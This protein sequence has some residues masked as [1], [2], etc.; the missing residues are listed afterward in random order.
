MEFKTLK[1]AVNWA[2]DMAYGPK[3]K[4]KTGT[5]DMMSFYMKYCDVYNDYEI[6]NLL[7]SKNDHYLDELNT[8]VH[9]CIEQAN[10]GLRRDVRLSNAR[11]LKMLIDDIRYD[12]F[13]HITN[14]TLEGW[15]DDTLQTAV[16]IL[17]YCKSIASNPLYKELLKLHSSFYTMILELQSAVRID[18]HI[19][20][21][22]KVKLK[23]KKVLKHNMAILSTVNLDSLIKNLSN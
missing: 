18:D 5:G 6:F 23:P 3:P 11:L 2:N 14:V 19:K 13:K 9:D 12:K 4:I 1:I 7:T 10:E 16:Q 8:G 17:K 22:F 21:L 15:D 20:G